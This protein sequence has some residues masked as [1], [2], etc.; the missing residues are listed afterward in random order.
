MYEFAEG[1]RN[2]FFRAIRIGVYKGKN[3]TGPK[4]EPA[5]VSLLF[6]TFLQR[7]AFRLDHIGSEDIDDAF[8]FEFLN[9][10]QYI[11]FDK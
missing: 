11:P 1:Q 2:D 8:V 10:H 6:S 9:N 7:L 4:F 3:L 5:E